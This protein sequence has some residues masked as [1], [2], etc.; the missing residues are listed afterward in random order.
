MKPGAAVLPTQTDSLA[1]HPEWIATLARWHFDQWGILTG[2]ET[3]GQYRAVLDEYSRGATIPCVL[4]A[5]KEELLGSV[6][7][8][9]CDMEIRADR[10]PWL[11][12]LFVTPRHRR[13]GAGATLVHAAL[14][15][16]R[17]CGFQRLHLYTSGTLP[18]FYERLGW[19]IDERVQY[20]G[21]QR[22]VMRYDLA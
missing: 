9:P 7:L 17:Q 1:R 14:S 15:H 16:A 22:T 2:S 18:D 4:V 12:Q 3:L 6:S 19:V 20:L 11:A 10:T 5:F 8:V 13:R 21:K